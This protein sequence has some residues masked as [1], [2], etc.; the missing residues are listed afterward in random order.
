MKSLW[1][2]VQ[3]HLGIPSQH[4][5]YHDSSRPAPSKPSDNHFHIPSLNHPLCSDKGHHFHGG[6]QNSLTGEEGDVRRSNGVI[7][8]DLME[9][10]SEEH[11]DSS[12]KLP[13]SCTPYE[14]G[15]LALVSLLGFSGVP[16]RKSKGHMVMSGSGKSD[17]D[18][19]E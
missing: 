12:H 15:N 14:Q 4:P 8:R 6:I 1:L 3:V 10:S 16:Y 2:A 11:H 5:Y 18:L 13:S 7:G 19:L 17:S 9:E